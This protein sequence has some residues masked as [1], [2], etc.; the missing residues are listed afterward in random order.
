MMIIGKDQAVFRRPQRD[1]GFFRVDAFHRVGERLVGRQRRRQLLAFVRRLDF[2]LGVFEQLGGDAGDAQVLAGLDVDRRLGRRV[3]EAVQIMDREEILFGMLHFAGLQP[4]VVGLVVR[5]RTRHQFQIRAVVVRQDLIPDA[6]RLVVAPQEEFLPFRIMAVRPD[7]DAG[8]LSV[9]VAAEEILLRLAAEERRGRGMD[10]PPADVRMVE[11]DS[12]VLTVEFRPRAGR[13]LRVMD[14]VV[15]IRREDHLILLVRMDGRVRPVE[16]RLRQLAVV[17]EVE[18]HFQAGRVRLQAEAD[19]RPH[20]VAFL[21]FRDPDRGG[22]VGA[23]FDAIV[24]RHKRRRPMMMREIPLH[25]AGHPRAQHADQRGLHDILPI[26]E[27]IV[28]RLV[29][30]AHDAAAEIRQ[31]FVAD[32][33]ILHDDAPPFAGRLVRRQLVLQRIRIDMALRALV[34]AALVENRHGRAGADA[35]RIQRFPCF[36]QAGRFHVF[37]LILWDRRD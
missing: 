15:H 7:H 12:L 32:V 20:A 27:I 21:R 30:S 4:C 8:V 28:V 13:I 33:F 3:V 19:F 23:A 29:E 22:A 25:A 14:G 18:I 31:D 36:R 26:E 17:A 2:D 11:F 5:I 16:E 35:V 24:R 34:A 6:G 10:L 37:P 9:V 1:G